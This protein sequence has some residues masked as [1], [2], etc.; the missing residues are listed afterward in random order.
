MVFEEGLRQELAEDGGNEDDDDASNDDDLEDDDFNTPSDADAAIDPVVAKAAK[1]A[2]RR[3]KI[4]EEILISERTYVQALSTLRKV[5]LVPLR[6]VA[7]AQG[8]GQIFSHED[9]DAVFINIDLCKNDF[10][11]FFFFLGLG[12]RKS[13]MQGSRAPGLT[14]SRSKSS[15]IVRKGLERAILVALGSISAAHRGRF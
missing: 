4:L 5:Y 8:K 15:E 2:A 1:R 12:V 9:L 3:L 13:M 14:F 10:A 11:I 6:M 7:D